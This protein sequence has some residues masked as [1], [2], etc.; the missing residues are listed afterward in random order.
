MPGARTLKRECTVTPSHR[1]AAFVCMLAAEAAFLLS[2]SQ[3][4]VLAGFR[5]RF[6]RRTF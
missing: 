1:K 6:S 2:L 3:L 4:S 5:A